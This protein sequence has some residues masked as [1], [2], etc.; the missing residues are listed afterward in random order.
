M[1]NHIC[2]DLDG[3]LVNSSKT[4]YKST[5][6]TLDFLKVSNTFEESEFNNRIGHHFKDIFSDLRIPVEDMEHFI[7]IYKSNYF[8]FIDESD[9][10]EGTTEILEHLHREKILISLLTTKAQ[11]QSEKILD[12]FKLTKYFHYI[13]GRRPY[14]NHKPSPEPLVLICKELMT[15]P[16]NTIMVGD[17]ELDILCGKNAKAK[18]CAVTYGYRTKESLIE[19]SPDYLID[20]LSEITGIIL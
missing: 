3:T 18:T 17:T 20:N 4:I 5:L 10:Y 9:L 19:L 6:E 15:S 8:N 1:I 11:D 14:I 12:H 13:M 2:F 16:A 7:N